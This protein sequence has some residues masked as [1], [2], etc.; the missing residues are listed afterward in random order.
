LLAERLGTTMPSSRKELRSRCPVGFEAVNI[1]DSRECPVLEDVLSNNDDSSLWLIKVPYDFDL[2]SLS[3]HNVVLNGSQDLPSDAQNTDKRYEVQSRTNCG[4]ELSSFTVLLPSSK[5][6]S[7]CAAGSVSGQMSVIRSVSVPPATLPESSLSVQRQPPSQFIKKWKP[8]GYRQ[9]RRKFQHTAE[10]MSSNLSE[11]IEHP[12][13]GSRKHAKERQ[14]EN[15][16][17]SMNCNARVLSKRDSP[18]KKKD[19]AKHEVDLS[20]VKT[21]PDTN[22]SSKS[23]ARN[24]GERSHS[25]RKRKAEMNENEKREENIA[26]IT[27]KKQK[28]LKSASMD[29]IVTQEP[30]VPGENSSRHSRKRQNDD[31]DS[32]ESSSSKQKKIMSEKDFDLTRVKTEP[33]DSQKRKKHSKTKT[34]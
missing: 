26:L 7:L 30:V 11:Q 24:G 21:E 18:K 8:F 14:R 3:G 16:D 6:K 34:C 1:A 27:S 23:E 20:Q 10:E 33:K 28:K 29:M 2:S 32:G 25:P 9:P 12:K 13:D 31:A 19:K 17:V 15:L 4:A 5:K 22:T